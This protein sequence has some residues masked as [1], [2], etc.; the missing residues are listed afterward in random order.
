MSAPAPKPVKLKRPALRIGSAVETARCVKQLL[1]AAHGQII[2]AEGQLW[3]FDKRCWQPIPEHALHLLVQSFDGAAVNG[4]R[5]LKVSFGFVTGTLNCL[6]AMYEEPGFFENRSW[7]YAVRM[8]S[9]ISR[10]TSWSPMR[11]SSGTA[12]PCL[13][14]G[15]QTRSHHKE[16]V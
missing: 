14:S 4:G 8:A 15:S 1:Q 2:G 7:E 13:E 9:L 5:P 10:T 6:A 11:P 12:L 3:F 16:N